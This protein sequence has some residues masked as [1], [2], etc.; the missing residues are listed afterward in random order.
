MNITKQLAWLLRLS[1]LVKID[2]LCEKQKTIST[3]KLTYMIA[4]VENQ[5]KECVHAIKM[6]PQVSEYRQWQQTE[7]YTPKES[8]EV[9]CFFETLGNEAISVEWYCAQ[10]KCFLPIDDNGNVL[11]TPKYWM[12][13][14]NKP[15]AN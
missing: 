12:R 15:K 8:G 13:L 11:N 1:E 9:L 6:S 3:N 4:D 10:E 14:P 7:Y 2:N 5:I